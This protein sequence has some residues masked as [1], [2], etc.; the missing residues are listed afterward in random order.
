MFSFNSIVIY[1]HFR[2]MFAEKFL[3]WKVFPLCCLRWI[4]Q[5][6]ILECPPCDGT[7]MEGG[8]TKGFLDIVR[9]L[10]VVWSK[11]EFVQS[12]VME[13]QACI[14]SIV[15]VVSRTK[16]KS[17]IMHLIVTFFKIF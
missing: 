16:K 12:T 2:A 8:K 15:N 17:S 1:V 13:Q 4:I 14:L 5:F 6:A 3:L 11:R 9:R 7:Q 10:A